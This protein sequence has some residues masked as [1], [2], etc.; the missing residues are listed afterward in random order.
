MSRT[1]RDWAARTLVY[2][3]L[4]LGLLDGW[5]A[6]TGRAA[7]GER[8]AAAAPSP[9]PVAAPGAAVDGDRRIVHTLSR[10][11]Y[12]PRPG[13]LER[14]R[15]MGVSAWID[16]QL[17]PRTIDDSV[18]ERALA[19]LPTLR[20]PIHELLREF[21]RPD[22]KMRAQIASGEMSRQEMLER[23]PMERRPVRIALEL[24]AAKVVRAV[25]SERQ[26]EEVMVDFW[27]NHFNVFAGK[28]DVRWYVSAYEREA[29][30]PY[31]MGRF[32][33]LVRAT[34]HHPAMLFYLDNW[35]S[36]RPDFTVPSGPNRGRK[37]GLNENYAREL[38]E[39]HTLGVDGGYT[40][41]DVTEVARAFTGW[42]ID[43]PQTD[44]R[45]VF[46]PRMHD[47]G[48]KLVL[49]HQIPAGG[50]RDDGERVMEILVRHPATARFVATKL[51]RRFVSDTPPPALVTRV[52][53]TY[54]STAGDI[55]SMLR[56][57]FESPEFSSEEAYRAKIKKPFE[58]VASAVRAL[59]G[60][61]DAQGAMALARASAEIGEPLYQ[62]QPPTG[63]ADRGEAWVNAGALL[64]R[65]NFAL[66]LASGRYPHVS[67][68]LAP[69]VSGADPRSPAAVLDRL[70]A[71][72]VADQAGAQTRAVLTAQLT[73][74]QITRLSPDDRGPANTDVAKLAALV[75]GSPEFQ[76]R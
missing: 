4:G 63:Y 3:A 47:T 75:I 72:I 40:Q 18:T 8:P 10:L 67:V 48:K 74:P 15:A 43:R 14:V 62:A 73:E 65:M 71:T 17:R 31:A 55:P 29:I 70:L 9:P 50:G 45:F 30:R 56:T 33:D 58:F 26:L 13:D 57:I 7:G 52:A 76:R 39:L 1:A 46:R 49:G 22:P 34:A 59:G 21:P 68:E 5:S 12:G 53:G 11:S 38:M 44:G 35:L 51:V 2:A 69:L 36:A 41:K 60:H 37:A 64:A 23:Y 42:T 24:Q 27:F 16:R 32:P 28:G 6:S 20:M 25:T 61:T 19:E 54:T 66:G